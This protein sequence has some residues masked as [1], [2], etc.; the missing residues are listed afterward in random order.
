[1]IFTP[2]A[3]FKTIFFPRLEQMALD[4]FVIFT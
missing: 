2:A 1:M 4:I 3:A